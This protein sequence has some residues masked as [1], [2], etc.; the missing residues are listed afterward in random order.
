MFNATFNNISVVSVE[1]TTNLP[2]IIDKLYHIMFF[3]YTSPWAEFELT[4]LVVVGTDCICSCKYNYHTITA[5]LSLKM[6]CVNYQYN[7]TL[8]CSPSAGRA[9]YLIPLIQLGDAHLGGAVPRNGKIK[10]YW[11]IQWFDGQ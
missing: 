2:K 10:S 4:T 1:K 7:E 5:T 6:T 9:I 11:C 8:M 3:E